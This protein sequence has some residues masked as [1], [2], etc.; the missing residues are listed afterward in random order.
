MKEPRKNTADTVGRRAHAQEQ[1]RRPSSLARDRRLVGITEWKRYS[2]R[3]EGHSSI[4]ILKPPQ[5]G[6]STR[7]VRSCPLH[8]P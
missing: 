6:W 2:T 7:V 8:Q 4:V 1:G 3:K 5:E